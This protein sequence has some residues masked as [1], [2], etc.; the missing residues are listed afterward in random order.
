MMH[1]YLTDINYS[2]TKMGWGLEERCLLVAYKE[3]KIRVYI[4]FFQP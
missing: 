4:D 3:R 1:Y 2:L